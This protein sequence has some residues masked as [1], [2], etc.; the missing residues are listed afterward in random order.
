MRY[1]QFCRYVIDL[2]Y[3]QSREIPPEIQECS[4]R[5][6]PRQSLMTEI[7]RYVAEFGKWDKYWDAYSVRDRVKKGWRFYV[8]RPKSGIRGWVWI[9]PRGKIEDLYVSRKY[10]HQGWGKQL[11]F[12]A[13]NCAAASNWP[14][15]TLVC[16]AWNNRHKYFIENILLEIQCRIYIEGFETKNYG[17]RRFKSEQAG[18]RY[19]SWAR[20]HGKFSV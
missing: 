3:Y 20:E 18:K 15:A 10:R 16:D 1:S 19:P 8:L 11:V 4:Y 7:K 14:K 9:S 5:Y 6:S 13:L 12:Q 2:G 17:Q